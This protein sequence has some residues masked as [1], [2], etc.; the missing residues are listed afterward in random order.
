MLQS[1]LTNYGIEQSDVYRVKDDYESTRDELS[2]M[3]SS[4]DV[5]LC[6]GGISVGDYDF[7]GKALIELDVKEIFYKIKQK[8]GKPLFFGKKENAL[9]FALPGNPAAA[10][11]CFNV[12]VIKALNLLT[13]KRPKGLVRIKK[14]NSYNFSFHKLKEQD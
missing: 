14:N 4:Y 3:L 12:Y 8:P 13:G 11:T 2:K 5:I 7:V 1:A 10:L 6:S 9:V